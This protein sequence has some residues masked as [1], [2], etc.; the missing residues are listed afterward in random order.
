MNI[1]DCICKK[2]TPTQDGRWTV[3]AAGLTIPAPVLAFTTSKVTVQ[4]ITHY[5]ARQSACVA[6]QCE[7]YE[8]ECKLVGNVPVPVLKK[9][10]DVWSGLRRSI[11]KA[12][13]APGV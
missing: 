3:N 4:A 13:R 11:G 5:Y 9:Q 12:K 8:V 7:P 6:L 1:Y 10:S 2:I